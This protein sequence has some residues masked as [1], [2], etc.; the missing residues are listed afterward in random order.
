MMLV[1]TVFGLLLLLTSQTMFLDV[2]LSCSNVHL[3]AAPTR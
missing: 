3:I 2:S 1:D